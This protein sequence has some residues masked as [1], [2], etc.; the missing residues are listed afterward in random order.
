MGSRLRTQGL[1]VVP[2]VAAVVAL[3]CGVALAHV[4]GK[5][6][7]AGNGTTGSA[8][9]T[10][11]TT[12]TSTARTTTSTPAQSTATTTTSP[13]NT[14]QTA[15]NQHKKTKPHKTAPKV[16]P[17]TGILGTA[18]VWPERTLML[19][20]PLHVTLT[21]ANLHLTENG[22]P[23]TGETITPLSGNGTS[24]L[25]V[26]AVV[27]TGPGMSG[28]PLGEAMNAVGQLAALRSQNQSLGVVT[29]GS[30]PSVL[31]PVTA[32]ASTIALDLQ[33]SVST[34]SSGSKILPALA[35][36]YKL[37]KQA[38]LPSGAVVLLTNDA[39]PELPVQG[40]WNAAVG[41]NAGYQTYVVAIG[42]KSLAGPS[43]ELHKLG[44][45]LTAATGPRLGQ[46]VQ[47]LW[48]DLTRSY[49]VTYKSVMP[50]GLPVHL[51]ASVA[52][53][54]GAVTAQ[55]T[56]T[57]TRTA[58]R[59]QQTAPVRWGR[60]GASQ[61]TPSFPAVPVGTPVRQ[62]TSGASTI[63]SVAGLLPIAI[64]CMLL[65]G[66]AV[67]LI[68]GR[69]RG[70]QLQ[71]R[72]AKFIGQPDTDDEAATGLEPEEKSGAWHKFLE[73][74]KSWPTFVA[75]VE[76]G[77]FKRSAGELVTFSLWFSAA[78]MALIYLLVGSL[79][80]A[81]LG[82]VIGP[83]GLRFY[84]KRRARKQRVVFSEQLPSH[85]HDL[86]GAMR[87]GRSM[88][89]AIA[90]VAENAD[91]PIKGELDRAI[92]DEQLGRP[93]EQALEG[94]AT[95]MQSPDM[96]QVA[97][98]ASLHRRTGSNVA[99]SL[100]RVAEGARDRADL[101]RELKAL[102]AQSKIS[103]RVLTALPVCLVLAMSVIAPSYAKPMF[104]PLGI[105]VLCFC[106]CL[107]GSG[108][109]VMKKITNVEG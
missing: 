52:G 23:I 28:A 64:V 14:N 34:T 101:K 8:A 7:G 100:E 94:I 11:T 63:G 2:I 25:G 98:I 55:Y 41:Q 85:L 43:S 12:T 103:S 105:V 51:A 87:A 27:D 44:A 90:T 62:P 22:Q 70:Q 73:A 35:L 50:L 16:A 67:V 56:A 3:L 68:L 54:P 20:L 81:L 83:L 45:P 18:S 99:E 65:I 59:S 33:T 53:V 38:K 89:S 6:S 4:A 31:V 57:Q 97:L 26:V 29:Y 93:L 15:A 24:K 76:V 71:A 49:L 39:R 13:A 48:G 102:T 58:T 60:H 66:V 80:L 40:N 19:T 42:P 108:W 72:V 1:R 9:A 92:A 78:A 95:R 30:K 61:L 104:K 37:L 21:Q 46:A 10:T 96:S 17:L 82:I 86:A 32:D 77:R 47:G 79:P 91:E 75:R 88:I 74:R 36:A 69:R 109:L 5:D 107:V 84:V 106:A